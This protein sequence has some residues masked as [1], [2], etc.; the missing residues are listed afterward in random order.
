V[1]THRAAD[2]QAHGPF[3]MGFYTREDLPYHYALADAFTVCDNYHWSV[4]GPTHPN[5]V[6]AISGT[7]DPDGKGGGPVV[8]NTVPA[9]GYSWTTYPERLQVAGISWKYCVANPLGT[10]LG[11]FTKFISAKPGDPLYENAM[12]PFSP[13]DVA[14]MIR[15]DSSRRLPG[16]T[17][18]GSR[19][20]TACPRRPRA[21]SNFSAAGAEYMDTVLDALG[22]TPEV[23]AKTVFI[24]NYD[25]NDGRFDH[26][27]PP[28]PRKARQGANQVVSHQEPGTRPHTG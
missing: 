3:T 22:S 19:R 28:T 17:R 4:F 15:A 20:S 1:P 16:W 6:M 14:D 18:S 25:E 23:W 26:V 7:M 24:I 12:I 11:W 9:P 27:P 21:P 8:D 13:A 5:R 2:G 10:D